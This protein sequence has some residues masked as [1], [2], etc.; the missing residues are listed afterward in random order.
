MKKIMMSKT[1]ACTSSSFA[2][3]QFKFVWGFLSPGVSMI[4]ILNSL[5]PLCLK[6]VGL[7]IQN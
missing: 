3:T 7:E 1:S 4:S 5:R 2:L 6:F